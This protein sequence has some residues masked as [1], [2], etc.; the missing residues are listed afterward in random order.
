MMPFAVTMVAGLLPESPLWSL[1]LLSCCPCIL[2]LP[3]C[4]SE[5]NW[6][7]DVQV[8]YRAA[9]HVTSLHKAGKWGFPEGLI[10]CTVILYLR[11]R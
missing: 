9:G 10:G 2:R 5:I 11:G 6:Y 7:A 1:L 4:C 3:A 8:L